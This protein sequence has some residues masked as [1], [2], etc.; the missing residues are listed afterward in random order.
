MIKQVTQGGSV[1]VKIN[2]VEGDFFLAGKGHRQGDPLAPLLFNFVVDIFSKMI[3]KGSTCGLGGT[4][5]GRG[6]CGRR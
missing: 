4:S 5:M 2:D 6:A 3:N 1:G